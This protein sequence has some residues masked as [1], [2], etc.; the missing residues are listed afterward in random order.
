MLVHVQVQAF[1]AQ[2][3]SFLYSWL[4]IAEVIAYTL[5]LA[6]HPWVARK[7]HPLAL[8]LCVVWQL[9]RKKKLGGGAKTVQNMIF[10]PTP[11]ILIQLWQIAAAPWARCCVFLLQ[12]F[13]FLLSQCACSQIVGWL[14]GVSFFYYRVFTLKYTP[15]WGNCDFVLYK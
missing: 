11:I 6:L 14:L 4:C 12:G 13:S 15:I 7:P 1:N 5:I 8:H 9:I 3:H 2:L 10:C